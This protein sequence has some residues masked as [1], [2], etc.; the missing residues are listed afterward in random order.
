MADDYHR[1]GRGL[2]Q[3]TGRRRLRVIDG[4]RRTIVTLARER[5]EKI[6]V[7]RSP[8]VAIRVVAVTPAAR[9]AIVPTPTTRATIAPPARR[10]IVPTPTTRAT[11]AMNRLSARPKD[12]NPRPSDYEPA[13]KRPKPLTDLGCLK[14]CAAGVPTA[15]LGLT[16]EQC[17]NYVLYSFSGGRD[18][19]RCRWR[20]CCTGF[21]LLVSGDYGRLGAGVWYFVTWLN[22]AQ[23]ARRSSADQIRGTST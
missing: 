17:V 5:G 6:A 23:T 9:W 21:A 18:G 15:G 4:W 8:M 1:P 12:L 16:L 20:D 3:F 22:S 11:T 14:L 10:W 13:A 7:G 2:F 19:S